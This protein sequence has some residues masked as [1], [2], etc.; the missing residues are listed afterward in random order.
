M[1]LH[2]GQLQHQH[3]LLLHLQTKPHL[4]GALIR[5]TGC[6]PEV[7]WAAVCA[8][9]VLRR[10]PPLL[11]APSFFARSFVLAWFLNEEEIVRSRPPLNRW[12]P[13]V[14]WTCDG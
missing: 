2:P 6:D 11:R 10:L 14:C 7:L 4:W 12:S 3:L 1:I 5:R 13:V 9:P 8:H